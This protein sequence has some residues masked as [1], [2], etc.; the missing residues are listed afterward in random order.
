ARFGVSVAVLRLL[1]ATPDTCSYLVEA[2][3]LPDRY[4]GAVTV[5][6]SDHPLRS[7]YARPG[8]P[9]ATVRWAE[10]VL[11]E[12]GRPLRTAHQIRTWNLS[13]IWRLDT[14]APAPDPDGASGP[15]GVSGPGGGTAW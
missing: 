6:L 9:A 7:P 13:A 12:R 3:T 14:A 15:D 4:R 10:Q 8:G 5:D 1:E 2:A 11:A